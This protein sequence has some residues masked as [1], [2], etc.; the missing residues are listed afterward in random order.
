MRAL[1]VPLLLV[2]LVVAIHSPIA[3]EAGVRPNVPVVVGTNP[4][5]DACAAVGVVTGLDP[6][7][8]GFLAVKS[9]P[10]LSYA[11]ID[12]LYNGEQ[13]FVCTVSGDWLGIVYTK[14]SQ[15]CNVST[16]WPGA[17][18]YTGPCRSGWAYRNWIKPL[19]G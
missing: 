11:R 8:D 13:I 15:Q 18:P 1:L 14:N 19:A 9:G 10:G 16:P 4:R 12:K 6:N 7:G 2:G 5:L 3:Q 17:M